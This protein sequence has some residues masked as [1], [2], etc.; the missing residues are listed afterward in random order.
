MHDVGVRIL[1]VCA[2]AAC[3]GQT[4]C[5]VPPRPT[6]PQAPFLWKAQKAGGPV[7]WLYGTIHNAG[8][9]DVPDVAWRA[10]ADS[11][12]FVSELGA[13][14]PDPDKTADLA[15]LPPG[16][17][18]DAQLPASDWYDLRDALRGVIKEDDLKR[19]RP[20]YAMAR[21]SATVAPSPSPT[22]D[23][24]LAERAKSKNVPVDALESWE[25]QLAAIA[26][27][28]QIPDLQQAIHERGRMRCELASLKA[29]YV[30]GDQPVMERR[31]LIA[32]THELVVERSKAWMPTIEG[33]FQG[34]GFVAVGLAHLLGDEGV[35]AMLERAGYTVERVGATSAID[36][37]PDRR[38]LVVAR[39]RRLREPSS[40]G[41]QRGRPWNRRRH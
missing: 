21:L 34:G 4:T 1:V 31:L 41:L 6:T 27:T 16:K 33:L 37:R 19:A 14:Q 38:A 22:M 30:A 35:P 39:T 13:T 12:R 25:V 32:E 15:R 23:F 11:P 5:P 40:C 9:E 10:L 20:W 36:P 7:V 3:G 28:V 26:D 8:A 29:S 17:G 18:L 24:A 2:L